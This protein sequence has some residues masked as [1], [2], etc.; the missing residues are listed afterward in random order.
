MLKDAVP[1]KIE[2]SY[3]I[4]THESRKKGDRHLHYKLG[5]WKKNCHFYILN[6]ISKYVTLMQLMDSLGNV[7]HAVSAFG[8]YIFD[9]NYEKS[10]LLNIDSL[11]LICACF[12]EVEYFEN[13]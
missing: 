9:S 1:S 8:E 13:S 12:D 4:M 11:N 5:Q 6:N 2:F 10:F 7:N 3:E